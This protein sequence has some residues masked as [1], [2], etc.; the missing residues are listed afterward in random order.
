MI[1]GSESDV[2]FQRRMSFEMFSPIW[3][4]IVNEKEKKIVKKIKFDKQKKNWSGDMVDRYLS[5]KF[6]VNS[7]GGI[8]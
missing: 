5:P 4:H 2:H 7:S 8:R 6:G 1:F 3:S